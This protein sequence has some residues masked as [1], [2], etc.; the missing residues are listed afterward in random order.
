[1][2][3][4]IRDELPNLARHINNSIQKNNFKSNANPRE[5]SNVWG[6]ALDVRRFLPYPPTPR[7]RR[8]KQTKAPRRDSPIEAASCRTNF[9][10]QASTSAITAKP[11]RRW[12]PA[13]PARRSLAQRRANAFGVARSPRR[14]LP[15][16]KP[17]T[18]TSKVLG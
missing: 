1:M 3:F 14:P 18:L 15:K 12:A 8:G 5:E 17:S 6:S 10:T 7:L 13:Q 2:L 9:E 16:N 11:F 4:Q